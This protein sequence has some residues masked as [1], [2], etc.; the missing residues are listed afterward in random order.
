MLTYV[1]NKITTNYQGARVTGSEKTWSLEDLETARGYINQKAGGSKTALLA[2]IDK[3]I[4]AV[5]A[6]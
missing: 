4:T 1:D 3:I 2:K 6:M 5:N